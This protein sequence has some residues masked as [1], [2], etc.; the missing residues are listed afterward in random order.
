MKG[1]NHMNILVSGALGRM[2]KEVISCIEKTDG[3]EFIC[4]FGHK[5]D[6]IRRYS[7]IF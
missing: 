4:G 6:M 5:S 2:G 1:T 7:C 3:F